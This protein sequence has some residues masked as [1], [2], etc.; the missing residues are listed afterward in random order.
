MSSSHEETAGVATREEPEEEEEE[1]RRRSSMEKEA[2]NDAFR[3]GDHA[4]A[5]RRYTAALSLDPAHH[6]CLSN[7]SAAYLARG[8]RGRALADARRCVEVAPDFVKGHTRCAA[9]AAA[10]GRHREALTVY[11]RVL[12]DM[13]PD[14][15]AA[16]RGAEECRRNMEERRRRETEQLERARK[17]CAKEKEETTKDDVDD[18]DDMDDFFSEVETAVEKTKAATTAPDA[19]ADADAEDASSVVELDDE[20]DLGGTDQIDRLASP[21]NASLDA[22]YNLNPFRVLGVPH[23]AAVRPGLTAERLRKRFRTLS[24]AVHPDKNPDRRERAERAFDAVRAAAETLRDDDRRR[25]AAAL[26]RRGLR[27]APKPSSAEDEDKAVFGIFA[28]VERRRRDVERRELAQERRERDQEDEEARKLRQEKAFDKSWKE[29]K[30]VEKRVGNWRDF[31][32]G[33]GPKKGRR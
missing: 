32:G 20:A 14:S 23:R 2:G 22:W 25:H 10:L 21:E 27:T 3:R 33:G 7:R 18:V 26:V 29:G 4:E 30:R 17:A 1:W 6:V 5:V 11:E 16:K 9:A 12:R 24:L 28:E 8:E 31:Q 13:D 19:D 15:A